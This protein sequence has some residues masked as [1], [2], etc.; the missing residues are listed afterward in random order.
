MRRQCRRSKPI[1]SSDEATIALRRTPMKAFA[2]ASALALALLSAGA[3]SAEDRRIAYGDLD[4][5]SV[6]GAARFDARIR[7]Q[8][9][10][11]CNRVRPIEA[12]RCRT[13][14]HADALDAL[15]IPR[16]D[17]YARAR[18]GRVLAM[19]PAYYG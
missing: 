3:A 2:A 16:Q 14:F 7:T 10:R 18:G 1:P 13:A 8:A 17:D 15:P 11:A 4:L 6:T 9:R 12:L 19:V 5:S